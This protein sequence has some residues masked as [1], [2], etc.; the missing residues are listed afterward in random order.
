MAT[1]G[2]YFS[3]YVKKNALNAAPPVEEVSDKPSQ[4]TI[5]PYK[6]EFNSG[7]SQVCKPFYPSF[8]HQRELTYNPRTL[9]D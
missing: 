1:W 9:S 5:K 6:A 8:K 3:S 2:A 7:P 4:F